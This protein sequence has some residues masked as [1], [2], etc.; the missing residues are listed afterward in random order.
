M[1]EVMNRLKQQR[2]K[3]GLR[4]SDVCAE[5]NVT[6]GAISKWESGKSLPRTDLLPKLATL[7]NCTIDELLDHQ[8]IAI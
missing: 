5:I 7:Y 4:Q 6:Q 3:V 2:E 1:G 8:T